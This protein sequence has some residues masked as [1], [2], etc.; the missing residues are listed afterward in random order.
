MFLSF[1][2]T[3]LERKDFKQSIK[4]IYSVNTGNADILLHQIHRKSE[5]KEN[6]STITI[7]LLLKFISRIYQEKIKQEKSQM[8]VPLHVTCYEFLLNRYG[9]KHVVDQNLKKV[10]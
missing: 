3:S 6:G 8:Y 2:K 1:N 7:N 9:L 4:R 5:Q 10:F